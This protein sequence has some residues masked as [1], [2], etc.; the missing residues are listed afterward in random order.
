MCIRDSLTSNPNNPIRPGAFARWHYLVAATGYR[1]GDTRR[2]PAGRHRP[3]HPNRRLGGVFHWRRRTFGA[4][5]YPKP[6][7]PGDVGRSVGRASHPRSRFIRYHPWRRLDAGRNCWRMHCLDCCSVD[8]RNHSP[9]KHAIC[10][11][12]DPDNT[13]Y[14]AQKTQ[15]SA[16]EG[17]HSDN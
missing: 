7:G 1:S 6:S 12:V 5:G 16:W 8:R 2:Q 9:T 13:S 15:G 3:Q 10:L 17:R 14:A 11:P 4:G